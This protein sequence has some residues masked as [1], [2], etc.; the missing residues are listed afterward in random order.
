MSE[1][2]IGIVEEGRLRRLWPKLASMEVGTRLTNI[3]PM[4]AIPPESGE[5]NLSGNEGNIIAIKGYDQGGWIYSAEVIDAGGV[6]LKNLA[7][8]VFTAPKDEVAT[9]GG[10][11]SIDYEHWRKE[12]INDIRGAELAVV[13]NGQVF[14]WSQPDLPAKLYSDDPWVGREREPLQIPDG[15][16][17]GIVT[18]IEPEGRADFASIT[19]PLQV[20]TIKAL[21]DLRRK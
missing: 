19:N 3:K 5:L 9:S 2:I 6:I 10:F 1:T 18:L 13:E 16:L 14:L 17:C 7:M 12:G 15:A 20:L 4:Q 11:G 21:F 8:E